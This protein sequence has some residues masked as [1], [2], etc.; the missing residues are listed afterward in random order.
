MVISYAKFIFRCYRKILIYLLL[1]QSVGGAYVETVISIK[2]ETFFFF[3]IDV[4]FLFSL[5]RNKGLRTQLS[6]LIIYFKLY[7]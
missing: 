4:F 6:S 1:F 5:L 7:P 3:I 2:F